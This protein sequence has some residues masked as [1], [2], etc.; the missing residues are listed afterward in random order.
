LHCFNSDANLCSPTI[1]VEQ[2][3]DV[4]LHLDQD[5]AG[6]L[7]ELISRIDNCGK[8]RAPSH[9]CMQSVDL[10]LFGR[11]ESGIAAPLALFNGDVPIPVDA[12]AGEALQGIYEA[13][14][15]LP[16][17]P[18]PGLDPGMRRPL[19]RLG[20]LLISVNAAG[21][22]I[23]PVVRIG[24]KSDFKVNTKDCPTNLPKC[25]DSG[26]KGQKGVC[27]V[28]ANAGCPCSN[29][30]PPKDR[31]PG[32]KNCGGQDGKS[33][34]CKGVSIAAQFPEKHDKKSNKFRF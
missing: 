32:C 16:A 13:G 11:I 33:P 26:C 24:S 14:M 25:S 17:A 8:K 34:K 1:T 7:D 27:T 3:G 6:R 30:C 31:T 18:G 29:S 21:T 12:A 9:D 2:N 15:A 4:L 28:G 22:G 20:F 10:D 19:L 23:K 5:F